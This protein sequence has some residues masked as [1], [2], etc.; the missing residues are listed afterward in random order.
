M[1]KVGRYWVVLV[2]SENSRLVVPSVS[3]LVGLIDAEPHLTL[4]F[5]GS[6][7]LHTGAFCHSQVVRTSASKRPGQS[8]T[9]GG[10]MAIVGFHGP[11]VSMCHVELGRTKCFSDRRCA[12]GSPCEVS[13]K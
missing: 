2:R 13:V 1:T 12:T 8:S 11:R 3:L 5:H 4:G 7:K 9:V 6:N 10:G